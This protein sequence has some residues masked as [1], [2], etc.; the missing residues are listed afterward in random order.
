MN[1]EER[2]ELAQEKSSVLFMK[3]NKRCMAIVSEMFRNLGFHPGQVPILAVLNQK[4]GRSLKEIAGFLQV[5]APTV[6]VSVQRLEKAGIVCRLPDE[7]D[8]RMQRIFL[9]EKGRS[10]TE[11]SKEYMAAVEQAMMKNF[12]EAELCLMRRFFVQILENLED[13]P[14]A[15]AE[16]CCFSGEENPGMGK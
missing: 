12:S 14:G 8:Q 13:F 6:T 9:T 15:L 3:I 2:K 16:E 5:T 4:D 1:E 10:L 11:K 7:K